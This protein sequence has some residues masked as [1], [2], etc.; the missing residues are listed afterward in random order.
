MND[1][2]GYRLELTGVFGFPVDENPTVVMMEA[3]FRELGLA[4]TY[5]TLKVPPESLGE[6]IA[7]IRAM[8]FRGLNLTI[9]H[10]GAVLRHLDEVDEGARIMGAVN[11]VYRK[12]DLLAGTNT[13]GKGFLRSLTEDAHINPSG[14]KALIFGAGGA[15]RAVAVELALAGA[16]SIVI[17]NR[18]EGRGRELVRLVRENSTATAEYR[19]WEKAVAI[20]VDTDIVVNATSI[21]LF[22]DTEAIPGVDFDTIRKGMIVCDVIP[23]PPRTRFLAEA[24]KR[25]AVTLDG[26]GM[27]VYQ[28]AIAF[29]LWTGRDAPIAV[30]KKALAS[31]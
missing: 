26:L 10:K 2:T 18:D 15:A 30:M 20:P 29:K 16:S 31:V 22:P 23:N 17:V 4:W 6:G 11:T 13:D 27:L 9:P 12:G 5:L 25:G 28:G 21:G 1:E 24:E 7:G 14:K 8:G 19:S 3:A